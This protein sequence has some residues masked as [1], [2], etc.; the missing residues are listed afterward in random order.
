MWRV[1]VSIVL[2]VAGCSGDC[3]QARVVVSP[4]SSAQPG[5][6][7]AGVRMPIP[8]YSEFFSGPSLGVRPDGNLLCETCDGIAVLDAEL[9]EVDHLGGGWR[10][11]SDGT[12]YA[13]ALVPRS[14]ND[15]AYL[16]A[17]SA[18]G[19][20]RWRV[21]VGSQSAIK[22]VSEP[23]TTSRALE[24]TVGDLRFSKEGRYVFKLV[25]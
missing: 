6:L 14:G 12:M 20:L 10:S 21:P 2:L 17:R 15:A 8:P 11:A 7:Q 23:F 22:A 24:M 13:L 4:S 3:E 18:T 16:V 25:L 1:I 5:A 19:Q 9:R